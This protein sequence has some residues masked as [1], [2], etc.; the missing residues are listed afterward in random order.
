MSQN[1]YRFLNTQAQDQHLAGIYES[2]DSNLI[3]LLKSG[4]L[5]PKPLM[6]CSGGTTSR[7]AAE[8]HWTLDL[9]KEFNKIKF[10]L[11]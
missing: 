3:N 10:I 11:G 7:C 5:N 9:R 6:I 8:G 4:Q 1:A 2:I